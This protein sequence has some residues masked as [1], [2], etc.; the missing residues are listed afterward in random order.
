[1]EDTGELDGVHNTSTEAVHEGS[2]VDFWYEQIRW[3]ESADAM[4]NN[5][6]SEGSAPITN[7]VNYNSNSSEVG[8]DDASVTDVSTSGKAGAQIP[9]LPLGDDSPPWGR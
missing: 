6:D 9:H 4:E 8:Y 2:H 3:T 5:S 7:N 1:M